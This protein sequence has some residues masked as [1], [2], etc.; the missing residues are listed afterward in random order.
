ME[1]NS[2]MRFGLTMSIGNGGAVT[3]ERVFYICAPNDP[4]EAAHVLIRSY[5]VATR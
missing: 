2:M 1:W 4:L 3:I 5:Q